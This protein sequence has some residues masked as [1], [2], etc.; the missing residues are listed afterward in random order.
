MS[1]VYQSVDLLAIWW[2][3]YCSMG[4]AVKQ[5]EMLLSTHEISS[6][7]MIGGNLP[8]NLPGGPMVCM[9]FFKCCFFCDG[10]IY[11]GCYWSCW[12]IGFFCEILWVSQCSWVFLAKKGVMFKTPWTGEY[13]GVSQIRWPASHSIRGTQYDFRAIN[14]ETV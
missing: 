6:M 8:A 11:W 2:C 13:L 1:L 5:A 12:L 14:L 4:E 10:W 9:C 7:S 3:V